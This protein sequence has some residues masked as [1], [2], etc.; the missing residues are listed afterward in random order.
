MNKHKKWL[1]LV[2][3]FVFA[4][5]FGS[6]LNA[7]PINNRA[8]VVGMAIDKAESGEVEITAQILMTKSSSDKS[9]EGKEIS[10]IG[11]TVAGAF[12]QISISTSMDVSLAHCNLIVLGK[13]IL[14]HNAFYPLDYLMRNA[15]LSEN[16]MLVGTMGKAK[17]ILK[18]E[19]AFSKI[20]SFYAQRALET[21]DDYLDVAQRT[22][23]SFAVDQKG[24]SSSNYLT[25]IEKLPLSTS[26]IETSTSNEEQTENKPEYYFN[27]EKTAVFKGYDMVGILTSQETLGLNAVKKS[28]S[29]G[30]IEI[31]TEDRTI[32]L[33]I[34][35][36]SASNKLAENQP[37]LT[38]TADITAILKEINQDKGYVDSLVLSLTDEEK[39][40]AEKYLDDAIHACF[41]KCQSLGVDIFDITGKMYRSYNATNVNLDDCKIITDINLEME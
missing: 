5:I 39:K 11:D 36:F 18:T 2:A 31:K 15:Y 41:L 23:K 25:L 40:A 3:A 12:S 1:A 22:I 28:V 17:D 7:K 37:V 38:I 20:S 29:Q 13:G 35:D 33:Y 6:S 10:A 24:Y 27:M 19:I 34:A 26:S 8:V 14:E 21:Q 9:L 30:S 4:L 32:D 16:A